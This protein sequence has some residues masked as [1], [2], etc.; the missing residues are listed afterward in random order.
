[1][2]L[3]ILFLV[4][5]GLASFFYAAWAWMNVWSRMRPRMHWVDEETARWDFDRHIWSGMAE[6]EIR[7]LYVA[8]GA[9]LTVSCGAAAAAMAISR[10]IVGAMMFGLVFL[11]LAFECARAITRHRAMLGRH[12]DG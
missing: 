7:R 8:S 1:M 12:S 10:N 11:V 9:A 5:L 6:V 3:M 4:C 2:A